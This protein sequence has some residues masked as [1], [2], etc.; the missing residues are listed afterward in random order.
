MFRFSEVYERHPWLMILYVIY[1]G[2]M[3]WRNNS[4]SEYSRRVEEVH[5]DIYAEYVEF[6]TERDNEAHNGSEEL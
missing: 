4:F 5:R 3:F 2:W 1:C 6:I